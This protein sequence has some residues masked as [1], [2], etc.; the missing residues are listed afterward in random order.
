MKSLKAKQEYKEFRLII[1]FY[2]FYYY[3]YFHFSYTEKMVRGVR[4]PLLLLLGLFGLLLP[5]WAVPPG[6]TKFRWFKF[7]HVHPNTVPCN[8]AMIAINQHLP[9]CKKI[10]TFLHDS[11][12]N[13]IGVC[14]RP[15]MRCRNDGNNCHQSSHTVNMTVCRFTGRGVPPNCQYRTRTMVRNYVVACSPRSVGDPLCPLLPVHL[16]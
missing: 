1:L 14:T 3:R 12:Q 10:N 8:Q 5:L 2:C 16:D 15:T 7:Q 6:F 9:T 4:F 11:L 13:V